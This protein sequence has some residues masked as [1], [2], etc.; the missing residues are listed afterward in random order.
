M[1]YSMPDI[2]NATFIGRGADISNML[3]DFEGN[4]GGKLVNSICINQENGI[5]IEY[6]ENRQ[7]SFYQ[8]EN[9]RLQLKN[10]IFFNVADNMANDIFKIN[11]E[12]GVDITSQT[13]AIQAYFHDA[14][15]LISDPV[16]V[17]DEIVCFLIPQGNVTGDMAEYPDQWFDHVNYKG[18]FGSYNWLYGWTLISE[19]GYVQ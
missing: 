10:N 19:E 7:D 17:I 18:A 8:F 6:V 13:E 14:G 9:G 1:P 12:P 5:F 16:I 11:A 15:N 4:A 2:Y 3:I